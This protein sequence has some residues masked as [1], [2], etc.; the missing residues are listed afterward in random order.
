M[1]TTAPSRSRRA[2]VRRRALLRAVPALA[3]LV[4]VTAC[5][6]VPGLY[7][8]ERPGEAAAGPAKFDATTYVDGIWDSKV[9]PTVTAGAV[10]ADELLPALRKDQK[11]AST[12]YGR[13]SGSGAPYAFMVKGT[14]KVTEVNENGAVGSLQVD[15]PGA[16]SD[17]NL[18]IGPA[19]VGTA[20]RDVVGLDFSQFTNQLDYADAATALNA[21]VKATVVDKVDLQSV[22]GKKITFTGAFSLLDPSSILVTPVTLEVAP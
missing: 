8:V 7:V 10:P 1:D 18:A 4:A 21:K 9:V 17:I 6:G 2:P 15:V 12:K 14:G 22:K 19:F 13:Q 16:G 20:I 3:M 5:S 11:A